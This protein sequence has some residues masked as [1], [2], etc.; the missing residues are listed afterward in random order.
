MKIDQR[1]INMNIAL[2]LIYNL[3]LALDQ[4]TNSLFLG[5]PDESLSSRLGRAMGKERYF[6]VSILR[7]AVD[8]IFFF[9]SEVLADGRTIRHCEKSIMPLEQQNFKERADY[10][11]WDWTR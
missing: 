2:R 9:D 5:H 4:L 10:E 6:W 7:A 8:T 1:G 3:L 11:I